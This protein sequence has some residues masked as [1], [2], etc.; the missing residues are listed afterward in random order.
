MVG[1]VV[2]GAGRVAARLPVPHCCWRPAGVRGGVPFGGFR[3]LFV[4]LTHQRPYREPVS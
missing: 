1:G 4:A 2:V 3:L